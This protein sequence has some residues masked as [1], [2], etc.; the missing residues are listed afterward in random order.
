[1]KNLKIE[2]KWAIVFTIALLAWMFLEKTLGWHEE[3]IA[4]H[5]WLTLLFMPIAILMYVLALREKRRRYYDKK[6]TWLQGFLSGLMVSV[7]V[8]LLSPVAQYVTH[9]Y[10]TPEYF[11][12]II[13]YSVTNEIMTLKAANEYFNIQSYMLQSAIGALAIGAITSA[14]VAVFMRRK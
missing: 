6:M 3:N 13:E 8:A 11:P 2:L 10:I 4:D 9:N 5:Y 1:M 7:F 14:I 12:N